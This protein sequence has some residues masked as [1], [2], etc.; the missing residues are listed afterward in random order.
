MISNEWMLDALCA[1]TNGDWFAE[2]TPARDNPDVKHAID[3]CSLCVVRHQCLEFAL[4]NDE[5]FGIW[6]GLTAKKRHR[7]R[8]R[9]D[10]PPVPPPEDWHGTEAGARRHYRRDE[11]ACPECLRASRIAKRDRMETSS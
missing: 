1:Q 8:T 7:I 5:R 4:V 10:L 9:L 6:G 3:V 2:Q 11:P